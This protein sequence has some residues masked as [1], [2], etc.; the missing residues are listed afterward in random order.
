MSPLNAGATA[1]AYDSTHTRLAVFD[2]K[3]ARLAVYQRSSPGGKGWTLSSSVPTAG[4]HVTVLCWA[5]CEYGSVIA[6]GAV[7]GSLGIWAEAPGEGS[8]LQL[9][10]S[11]REAT[12]AV[13]D[14]AFAPAELGPLLAVAYA[15]GF[16]RCVWTGLGTCAAMSG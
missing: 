3:A 16:V 7:D 2:A 8:K 12:L 4:L 11:P 9:V 6:G 1:V 10:A 14:V 13:Q 15:D 5:P